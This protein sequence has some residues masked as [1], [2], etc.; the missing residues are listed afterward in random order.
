[1]LGFFAMV[2]F[3]ARTE[4]WILGAAPEGDIGLYPQASMQNPSGQLSP[5]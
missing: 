3:L 5:D 4:A 1:M 2:A